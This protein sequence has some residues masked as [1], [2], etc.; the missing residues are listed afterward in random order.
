[1][2]I[3]IPS[4]L[5]VQ[6][7]LIFSKTQNILHYHIISFPY[8]FLHLVVQQTCFFRLK[9]VVLVT[10]IIIIIIIII[11]VTAGTDG[12]GVALYYYDYLLLSFSYRVFTICVTCNVISR[13]KYVLYIYNGSLLLLSSSS[14]YPLFS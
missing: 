12:V 6:K 2:G 11:I 14:S 13:V 5:Q 3:K 4:N 8:D 10:V 9:S 1:M 7:G